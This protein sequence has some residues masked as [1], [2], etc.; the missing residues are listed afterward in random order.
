MPMI[1][2][3]K[4]LILPLTEQKIRFED[5]TIG[6][7]LVATGLVFNVGVKKFKIFVN[8]LEA[9]KNKSLLYMKK[10][11]HTIYYNAKNQKINMS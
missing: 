6:S 8:F 9:M 11:C 1:C 10:E 7:R 5:C 3:K 2:I 4:T